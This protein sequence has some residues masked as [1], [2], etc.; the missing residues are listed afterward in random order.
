[1]NIRNTAQLAFVLG[2]FFGQDVTLK[3]VT[4]FNCSARANAK[5]FFGR[6]LRLHFWHNFTACLE[7]F[8]F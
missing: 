8:H 2:G 7:Q 6:T 4:T 1:M 5:A 3:S